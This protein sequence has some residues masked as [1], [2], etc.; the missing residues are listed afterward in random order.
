MMGGGGE[1]LSSDERRGGG[2]TEDASVQ[3]RKKGKGVRLRILS[4]NFG[5]GIEV[6]IY[7]LLGT[8]IYDT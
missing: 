1:P 2:R 7:Y 8:L 5:F 4:K 3:M 6:F